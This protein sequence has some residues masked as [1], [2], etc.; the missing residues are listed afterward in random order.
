LAEVNVIRSELA[1]NSTDPKN[2]PCRCRARSIQTMKLC[3]VGLDAFSQS[4]DAGNT[5]TLNNG[6][7]GN[8]QITGSPSDLGGNL[9][10]LN[11]TC[12]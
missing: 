8:P 9:C 10:G 4:G 7:I 11:T 2:S 3:R 1:V 5:L 6:G 12:P